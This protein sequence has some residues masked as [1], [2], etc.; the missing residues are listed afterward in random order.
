MGNSLWRVGYSAARTLSVALVIGALA[1]QTAARA[2]PIGD[3]T[4]SEH[5]EDECA[6]GLCGAFFSVANFSNDPDL[7]LGAL[8]ES[9]FDVFVDLQTDAG[10]PSVL[11]GGEIASGNSSQSIDDLFGLTVLS[12]RLRLTFTV[13]T[14]PGSLRLLDLD[15]IAVAGLIVPGSLLIDYA[16]DDVVPVPE[17]PA[18]L[19]LAGG[20]IGIAAGRR[21]QQRNATLRNS[22]MNNS[23][24]DA[25]AT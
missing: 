21:A 9:F 6:A 8:G 10:T 24:H 13:P 14:L 7:S 18:L 4:W 5:T 19:L 25:F 11:V 20:L 22:R 16:I 1:I 12:A 17:P 3:F 15:G 2:I 23:S